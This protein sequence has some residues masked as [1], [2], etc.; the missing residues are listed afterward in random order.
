ML[1]SSPLG[2]KA[3]VKDFLQEKFQLLHAHARKLLGIAHPQYIYHILVKSFI[4]RA[5]HLYRVLPPNLSLQFAK[6][7]DDLHHQIFAQSIHQNTT[8]GFGPLAADSSHAQ[9]RQQMW[10]REQLSLPHR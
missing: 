4:H 7:C 6:Q 10:R 1:G 3:Y 5:R 8:F 9:Q 2:T